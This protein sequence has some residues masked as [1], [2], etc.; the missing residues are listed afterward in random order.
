MAGK[1][2]GAPRQ[3]DLH[4]CKQPC[5]LWTPHL[6]PSRHHP[7]APWMWGCTPSPNICQQSSN[8]SSRMA[9]AFSSRSALWAGLQSTDT[10]WRNKQ[11]NC[12]V[13]IYHGH[14]CARKDPQAGKKDR[15]H[16][17]QYMLKLET[18]LPA[19][20]IPAGGS[21]IVKECFQG[22]RHAQPVL[23]TGTTNQLVMVRPGAD[24]DAKISQ[25][26]ER[27]L[28]VQTGNSIF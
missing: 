10:T 7:N 15:Q 23:D 20:F 13:E 19:P 2:R 5:T 18:A 17:M 25:R 6:L 28:Y 3:T 21:W 8:S 4:D 26:P 27:N 24:Q 14:R 11:H 22:C 1:A 12:L 16:D 9:T